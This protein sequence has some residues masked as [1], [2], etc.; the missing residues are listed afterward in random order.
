MHRPER[1]GYLQFSN[2]TSGNLE[3][4]PDG[5]Q[6]IKDLLHQVYYSQRE[7]QKKNGR[8]ASTPDALGI[9]QSSLGVPEI[10]LSTRGFDAS[11]KS[12]AKRWG[13]DSDSLLWKSDQ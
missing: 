10:R 13:I 6:G 4:K 9:P 3:Y 8:Y 2:K 1:W 7:Y 5:T 11:L 12:G